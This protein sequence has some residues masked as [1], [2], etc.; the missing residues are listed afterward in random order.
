M[1]SIQELGT[2]ILSDS[3]K[4]LYFLGG[5][6]YGVKDKYI[7][8][9]ADHYQEMY[10]YSSVM[11]VI[12]VMSTRHLIPLKPALY[13]VRYDDSFVS[14]L[15]EQ[16]AAK[17]KS[18]NIIGTLLC[19]YLENKHID[20]ID[21]FFPDCTGTVN[22]VNP[23]F[24]EKYLHQDFPKLDDR[25]IKV[26]VQA[27]ENYGHA[28][29][30]CKSMS[31]ADLATLNKMTEIELVELFGCK[32]TSSEAAIQQAIANRNFQ[33]FCKALDSYQGDLNNVVYTFLQ[34][35]I[36]LEKIKSSKYSNSN[37][38]DFARFWKIEDIYYMFMNAYDQLATLRSNTS[39]D[40]YS[41]L[42]YLASLLTFRDIPSPEVLHYGT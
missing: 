4:R 30:I 24:V 35:M 7:D 26:A 2:S 15:N 36:E 17:V 20:K 32:S 39:S 40:I 27:S 33:L 41:T 21:K 13:V 42:I 23:K 9:L 18:A 22:L 25:S 34:T 14:S 12:T 38:R 16:V 6:E 5:E 28:R 1:I 37:L 3:P 8:H 10:T 11:D 19:I 31:F 29:N